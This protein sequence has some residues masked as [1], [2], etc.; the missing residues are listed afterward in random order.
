MPASWP[1]I[2][3]FAIT[4]LDKNNYQQ[5]QPLLYQVATA[6]LGPNNIAFNLRGSLR[7]YP[8]VHV[9]MTEAVSVDLNTRVVQTAQGEQYQG[10][11]TKETRTQQINPGECG[12]SSADN[13]GQ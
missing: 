13:G 3:T 10:S 12:W 11:N 1:R 8:N 4:L 6:V 9:K 2:R 5:F 7:N